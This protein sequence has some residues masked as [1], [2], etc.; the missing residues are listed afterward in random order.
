MLLPCET[1]RLGGQ[2]VCFDRLKPMVLQRKGIRPLFRP[3]VCQKHSDGERSR[4]VRIFILRQQTGW[5]RAEDRRA[6]RRRF[7]IPPI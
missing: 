3:L 2:K 4:A 7:F 6:M 5:R 1:I